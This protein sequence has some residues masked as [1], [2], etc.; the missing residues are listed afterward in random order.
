LASAEVRIPF[1][2]WSENRSS[3][4][5][6]PFVDFGTTWSN[7]DERNQEEDTVASLGLGVRL[8]IFETLN[9]RLD[10]GIPLIEVED[11]DDT[12]QEKDLYFSLEYLPF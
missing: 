3:L 6:V 10:Y 5:A 2:R 8:D 9:A 1:Y 7:S 4:S 12:L 11:N